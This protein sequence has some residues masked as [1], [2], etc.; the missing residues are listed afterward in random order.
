MQIGSWTSHFIGTKM[1]NVKTCIIESKCGQIDL[2]SLLNCLSVRGPGPKCPGF[3]RRV[4]VHDYPR[5]HGD[6]M[7]V[8]QGNESWMSL[9]F[10]CCW[11]HAEK[12]SGKEN[13]FVDYCLDNQKIIHKTSQEDC[14]K[15]F[16]GDQDASNSSI[17]WDATYVFPNLV[18][19]IVAPGRRM[20]CKWR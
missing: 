18:Y 8:F 15:P 9:G 19:D 20:S 5:G 16:V 6:D 12:T 13:L 10:F 17:Q 2:V 3:L 1:Q 7:V 4:V 14:W 11:A